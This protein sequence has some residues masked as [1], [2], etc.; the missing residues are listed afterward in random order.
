[1]VPVQLQIPGLELNKVTNEVPTEILC[2]MNMVLKDELFDDEE[3]EGLLKHNSKFSFLLNSKSVSL[4]QNYR[5]C[6]VKVDLHYTT[7]A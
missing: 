2:L 3:Y 1:M 4:R 7:F 6:C 5:A